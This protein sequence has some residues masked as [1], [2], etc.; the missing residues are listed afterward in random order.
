MHQVHIDLQADYIF[1]F[2]KGLKIPTWLP[3]QT[4]IVARI[5]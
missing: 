5:L 3:T 2:K 1:H 4:M